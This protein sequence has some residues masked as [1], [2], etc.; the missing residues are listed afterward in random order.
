MGAN[1]RRRAADFVE[2]ARPNGRQKRR[3]DARPFSEL[4]PCRRQFSSFRGLCF[5]ARR[6]GFD[7]RSQVPFS[8]RLIQISTCFEAVFHDRQNSADRATASRAPA[9]SELLRQSIEEFRGHIASLFSGGASSRHLRSIPGTQRRNFLATNAIPPVSASLPSAVVNDFELKLSQVKDVA[10]EVGL[11]VA[12]W[13][14]QAKNA[15]ISDSEISRM[16]S[17][18]WCRLRIKRN[19]SDRRSDI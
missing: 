18:F 1:L 12:K 8:F 15:G 17:L 11:V 2:E 6:F 4:K 5:P 3:L 14:D 10:A 9:H 13:R 7:L 19:R 16:S